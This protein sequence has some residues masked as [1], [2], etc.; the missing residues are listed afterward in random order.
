[1]FTIRVEKTFSAAHRVTGPGGKCEELHGHTYRVAVAVESQ[2]LDRHG[3]VVDFAEV[4][5]RLAAVLPDHKYLNEF[6]DF[7]PTAENLARHLYRELARSGP[8]ASVRVW[9]SED[10]SAEFRPAP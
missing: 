10:C 6:Y 9:E 3:M 2:A 4:R 7:V 1:M 5:A 8:V